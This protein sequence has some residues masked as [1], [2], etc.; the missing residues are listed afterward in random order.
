M[1]EY[2]ENHMM[3]EACH[4]YIQERVF[5][6]I[7]MVSETSAYV[8]GTGFILLHNSKHYLVTARHVLEEDKNAEYSSRA[9]GLA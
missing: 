2:Y 7:Y 9:R 8:R 6:L 5:P 4:H 3:L 1:S